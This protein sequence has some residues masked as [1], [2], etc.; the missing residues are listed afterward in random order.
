M[1]SYSNCI[2]TV[3]D[4]MIFINSKMSESKLGI[5]YA[6]YLDFKGDIYKLNDNDFEAVTDLM[7]EILCD[8]CLM[9]GN[10]CFQ[11]MY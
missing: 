8:H 10:H 1:N 9:V 4:E 11:L 6:M 5:A 7:A 3:I 2:D